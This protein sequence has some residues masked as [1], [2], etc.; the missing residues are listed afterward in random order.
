MGSQNVEVARVKWVVSRM[1]EIR[2]LPVSESLGMFIKCRI[3][4]LTGDLKH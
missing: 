1:I 3:L 2:N 4:A